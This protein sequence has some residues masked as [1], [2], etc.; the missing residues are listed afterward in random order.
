V[1][2][3]D[4]RMREPLIAI[5]N[6]E[7]VKDMSAVSV[8]GFASYS[9]PIR[10][11]HLRMTKRGRA[12]LL[13]LVATPVVIAALAFGIGAGGATATNSSTPLAKVTVVGG[14]TLWSVAKQIAPN[15]DP[16]DVVSDIMSV[17]RLGTADI[18]PGEQLSIPAKYNH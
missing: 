7:E 18:H 9:V 16:R 11:S 6:Q 13:S 17:N 5:E 3:A 1:I 12:V 10:R 8:G 2:P 4:R 15:A 14:E